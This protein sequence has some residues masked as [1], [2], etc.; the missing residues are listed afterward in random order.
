MKLS[1]DVYKSNDFFDLL[2]FF[3]QELQILETCEKGSPNYFEVNRGLDLIYRR[4]NEL[5]HT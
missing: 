1:K 5:S 4:L 3:Y 2:D